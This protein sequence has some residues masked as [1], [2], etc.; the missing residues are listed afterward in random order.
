MSLTALSHCGPR[1]SLAVRHLGQC[2]F[3]CAHSLSPT[4]LAHHPPLANTAVQQRSLWAGTFRSAQLTALPKA[5]GE[6][7][8][9]VGHGRCQCRPALSSPGCRCCCRLRPPSSAVVKQH[10]SAVRGSS[11]VSPV[12]SWCVQ[13]QCLLGAIISSREIQDDASSLPDQAAA[14]C[15]PSLCYYLDTTNQSVTHCRRDY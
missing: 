3:A 8:C 4:L 7:R 5:P 13:M 9:V 14:A 12:K 10:S 15:L 11:S 1:C 6:S 2:I